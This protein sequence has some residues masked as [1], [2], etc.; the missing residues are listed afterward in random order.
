[1][2]SQ[3]LLLTRGEQLC[4]PASTDR[5][6]LGLRALGD[7]FPFLDRS[8][9]HESRNTSHG[10]RLRKS[11][12]MKPVRHRKDLRERASNSFRMNTYKSV[13]A[14]RILSAFRINTA[15]ELRIIATTSVIQI[16]AQE[17]QV[18]GAPRGDSYD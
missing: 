18:Q 7:R 10:S 1:M 5:P 16:R 14:Q 2:P 13:T 9:L 12:R 15:A 8:F 17:I 3:P 6:G 11:F 4:L